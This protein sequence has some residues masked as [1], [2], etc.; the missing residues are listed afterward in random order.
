[1]A[2]RRVDGAEALVQLT[3]TADDAIDDLEEALFMLTLLPVEA[4]G[5]V[6]SAL[7]GLAEVS[8][9]AAKEHLKAL[10]ISRQ[11]V[12]GAGPEDLED[13]LVAVDRVMTLEH[14]ADNRDR[15]AGQ[16]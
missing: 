13:F 3:T 9:S 4:I 1:M 10:L 14:D 16:S 6:R 8:V 5:V 2:A 15:L 11:V 7:D 12:D